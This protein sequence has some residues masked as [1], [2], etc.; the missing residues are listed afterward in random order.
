MDK[1]SDYYFNVLISEDFDNEPLM[2]LVRKDFFDENGYLDDCERGDNVQLPEVFANTMEATFEIDGDPDYAK[3]LMLNAGF[4][5]NEKVG[6]PA[7]PYRE[8][9]ENEQ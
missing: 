5:W 8:D 7:D 3:N 1:P 4:V 2:F 9:H 6:L